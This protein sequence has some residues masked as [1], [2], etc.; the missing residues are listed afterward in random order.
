VL[1]RSVVNLDARWQPDP[2]WELFANVTNLFNTRYQNFG[3][4]GSNFFRG[5]GNTFAPGLAGPEPFR[6]PA[7]PFGAWLGVQFNFGGKRS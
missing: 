2:R 6:A 5:P 7:T 1:F 3:I 4:L